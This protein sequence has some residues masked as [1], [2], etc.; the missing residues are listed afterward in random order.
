MSQVDPKETLK[1]LLSAAG[2]RLGSASDTGEAGQDW[3]QG[4]PPRPLRGVPYGGGRR[5]GTGVRADPGAYR[6]AASAAGAGL[7]RAA[8]SVERKAAGDM[9]LDNAEHGH[10]HYETALRVGP[11]ASRSALPTC[12]DLQLVMKSQNA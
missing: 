9:C 11:G 1:Q 3:I 10:P 12:S 5:V 2:E 4:C 6:P 7:T 8:V